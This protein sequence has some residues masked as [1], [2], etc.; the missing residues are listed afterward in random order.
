MGEEQ[1]ADL[2]LM[3]SDSRSGDSAPARPY[4]N[5]VAGEAVQDQQTRYTCAVQKGS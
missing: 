3:T 4:F 5:L 2:S 1:P